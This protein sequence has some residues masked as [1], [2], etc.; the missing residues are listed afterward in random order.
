VNVTRVGFFLGALC[1]TLLA[2]PSASAQVLGSFAWQMQP[3]CNVVT[4]TLTSTPAGYTLDGI[5]DQCAAANK[6]SA[7]GVASFNAGGLVNVNLTVV[8]APSGKAVHVA[9]VV[10]PATGSG[11]WTD[12]VGNSGTFA[13]GGSTPGLPVRPFPASGLGVAVITSA[14]IAAGAVGAG[15]I[16][17]AEVQARITGTCAAGQAVTSV[18]ADGTVVCAA[19]AGNVQFHIRGN[20]AQDIPNSVL[21]PV[22]TWAVQ[23]YND[24]GGTYTPA[25]GTYTIPVTGVY[26][27]T[28]TPYWRG[29]ASTGQLGLEIVRNLTTRIGFT[30][31]SAVSTSADS[32]APTLTTV[33]KFSA[34]DTVQVRVFQT[35]GLIRD[36]LINAS[37]SSF[38]VTL[39]R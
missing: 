2:A 10:S 9:A 16:N 19:V 18:N 29:Y 3:Y 6:A 7:V 34:G 1:V 37:N 31:A 8:T 36:L 13:L 32:I 23:A 22:T 25:T 33:F 4:L 11:T 27:V 14:E 12:S 39:I 38:V 24:G 15:D 20:T 21:T 28:A 35:S 17:T 26:S 5:D 30:A